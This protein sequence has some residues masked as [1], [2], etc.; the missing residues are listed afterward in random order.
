MLELRR[1]PNNT[2]ADTF[3]L[4]RDKTTQSVKAPLTTI[5]KMVQE[6][7][8]PRV[9]YIK[10]DIEG[11]EVRAIRG[12][13]ATIARDHPRMALSAYHEPDHAVEIPKAVRE[14]WSGY[15]I[16]SGPCAYVDKITIRPDVL[17]FH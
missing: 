16:E 5:D 11:A 1:D 17:Y 14:A 7:K 12:A 9:D 4:L 8:L 3:V 13:R 6:L 2:A 10:M 15:R